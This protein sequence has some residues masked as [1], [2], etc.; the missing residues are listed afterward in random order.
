MYLYGES[1]RKRNE[2]LKALRFGVR[3]LF[4]N[5][6]IFAAVSGVLGVFGSTLLRH[7]HLAQGVQL[8]TK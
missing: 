2:E 7:S 5:A 6:F 3:P 1:G 4:I 8:L